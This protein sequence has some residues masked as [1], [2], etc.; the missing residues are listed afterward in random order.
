MGPLLMDLNDGWR[1]WAFPLLYLF[2]FPAFF[3]DLMTDSESDCDPELYLR[4]VVISPDRTCFSCSTYFAG[5][6]ITFFINVFSFLFNLSHKR[7]PEIGLLNTYVLCKIW[8]TR[9]FLQKHALL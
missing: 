7:N 4:E 6:E 1:E 2:P 5:A 3:N 8:P 9:I